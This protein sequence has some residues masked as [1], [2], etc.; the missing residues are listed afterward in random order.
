M[1]SP[2][3]TG[4]GLWRFDGPLT[5]DEA[6]AWVAFGFVSAIG[7]ESTAA[8][9]GEVLGQQVPVNRERVCL[10]IGDE[11][12]V[13]RLCQRLPEGKVLSCADLEQIPW[14]LGLLTK[15]A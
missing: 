2:V 9:L 4:F 6:R 15:L 13:L 12:M 5:L 1:N 10:E 14:E 11:A 7:H 8:M 3:L